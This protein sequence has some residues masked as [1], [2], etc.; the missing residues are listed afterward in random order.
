MTSVTAD[1][2]MLQR[3]VA[4]VQN[5]QKAMQVLRDENDALKAENQ[6]L[7]ERIKQ[8][9]TNIAVESLSED[10]LITAAKP[11]SLQLSTKV[12]T[13]SQSKAVLSPQKSKPKPAGAAISRVESHSQA[14]RTN[15]TA[16]PV[17]WLGEKLKLPLQNVSSTAEHE[18]SNV[19]QKSAA[20]D[21]RK[22]ELS[23]AFSDELR[24]RVVKSPEAKDISKVASGT[25]S[26]T[27]YPF[28]PKLMMKIKL[29][30]SYAQSQL[31]QQ[32][33]SQSDTEKGR[34]LRR[35]DNIKEV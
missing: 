16:V 17:S 31:P 8:L 23:A 1:G 21:A 35:V 15:S 4:A 34:Q 9:E 19:P 11:S 33:L 32:L 6:A 29:P 22:K 5:A 18:L 25:A 7:K 3:M 27:T 26:A 10:S 24:P 14:K 20:K 12:A 13:V 2:G 28:T 30:R